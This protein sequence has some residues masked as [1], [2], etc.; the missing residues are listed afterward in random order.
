MFWGPSGAS[1]VAGAHGA[2]EDHRLA[3]LQH[4]LQE[5]GRLLQRIGPVGDDDAFDGAIRQPMGASQREFAPNGKTHVLAVDLS[6][7]LGHQIAFAQHR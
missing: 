4:R 2:G 3:R 6:H 1:A 7:L 5:P